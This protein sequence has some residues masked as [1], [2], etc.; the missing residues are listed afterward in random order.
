ML[1]LNS[2]FGNSMQYHAVAHRLPVGCLKIC[3]HSTGDLKLLAVQLYP[4]EIGSQVLPTLLIRTLGDNNISRA[5][6]NIFST[7]SPLF[8][9]IH[10]LSP[11]ISKYVQDEL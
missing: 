1:G 4:V 10:S 9:P 3:L 6:N 2:G 5:N 7:Q 11:P 8:P